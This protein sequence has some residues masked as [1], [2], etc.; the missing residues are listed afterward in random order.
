MEILSRGCDRNVRQRNELQEVLCGRTNVRRINRVGHAIKLELLARFGIENLHRTSIVIG[1]RRKIAAAFRYRWHRGK[2]IIGRAAARSIPTCKEKPFVA[3]V[4]KL[5]DIQRPAD[6]R[7]KPRLI[8]VRFVSG[9]SRQR[10]RLAR[11]RVG[12]VSG[13][14]SDSRHLAAAAGR[15][16]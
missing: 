7:S 4:E 10:V 1:C 13:S 3:A 8:V 15:P 2:K 16:G 9:D 11:V 12:R 5:R 14:S 6:I